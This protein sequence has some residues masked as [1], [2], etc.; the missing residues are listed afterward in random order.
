MKKYFNN[1]KNIIPIIILIV[2]I[3]MI[4]I[5]II[6]SKTAIVSK[7]NTE[8][9]FEEKSSKYITMTS[10][11][12]ISDDLVN[13][14]I[15][16]NLDGS[17]IQI[18][19]EDSNSNI[20]AIYYGKNN[21]NLLIY[22]KRESYINEDLDSYEMYL[23]LY[24]TLKKVN[25]NFKN[26]IINNINGENSTNAYGN[27]YNN[28]KEWED[29][30]NI[31]NIEINYYFDAV[32]ENYYLNSNNTYNDQDSHIKSMNYVIYFISYG[33]CG[34]FASLLLFCIINKENYKIT[35]ALLYVSLLPYIFILISS[36]Y[37]IF[38]G[39]C[40]IF[41]CTYDFNAFLTTFFL[42]II[43]MCRIP[44]IPICIAC[45]FICILN[46]R[47]NKKGIPKKSKKARKK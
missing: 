10:D 1:N 26:N 19:S 42:L 38:S 2:S 22:M 40:F 5:P 20:Y 43:L 23:T 45:Q 30:E 18:V 15:K 31:D 11:T 29:I 17:T 6:C 46:I 36:I 9:E 4:I 35:K 12:N 47:K 7:E 32:D 14:K 13:K 34:I 21:T 27:I 8:K 41:S 39:F 16:I 3:L 44:I 24:G 33:I 37:S 25:N 28:I